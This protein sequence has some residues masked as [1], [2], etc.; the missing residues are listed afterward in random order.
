MTMGTAAAGLIGLIML[1]SVA[2]AAAQP[3]PN[4][5]AGK[6]YSTPKSIVDKVTGLVN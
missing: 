3:A 6:T 4:A 1:S 2:P 5:F